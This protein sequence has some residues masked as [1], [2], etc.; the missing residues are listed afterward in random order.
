MGDFGRTMQWVP[1][2]KKIQIFFDRI[3]VWDCEGLEH[4]NLGQNLC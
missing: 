3:L 2:T 4:P 1:K